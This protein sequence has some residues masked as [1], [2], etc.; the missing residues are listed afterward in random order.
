MA[1]R[2]EVVVAPEAVVEIV[3]I[4]SWWR[5]N[6]PRSP[7]IFQSEMDDALVLISSHPDIG[8]TARSQRVGN[9]RVIE[10]R[11]SR[12]RIQYQINRETQEVLVVPV[13]HGKRRPLRPR[14]R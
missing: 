9:A 7:R 14:R 8:R 13:R 10:L 4:S 2:Y 11:R 5:E 12:Y 3:Q 1:D 6:R